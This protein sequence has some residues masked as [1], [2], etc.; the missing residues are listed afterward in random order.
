[1][2]KELILQ[3]NYPHCLSSVVLKQRLGSSKHLKNLLKRYFFSCWFGKNAVLIIFYCR[4]SKHQA[5]GKRMLHPIQL[6]E[7]RMIINNKAPLIH[8]LVNSLSFRS[9]N[10]ILIFIN[11]IITLILLLLSDFF[12]TKINAGAHWAH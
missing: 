11:I 12:Q 5:Y 9:T 4:L 1:M 8:V 2:K 3:E 10:P 6:L 7:W